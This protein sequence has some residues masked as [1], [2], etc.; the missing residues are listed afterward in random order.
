MHRRAFIQSAAASAGSAVF[1]TA[2]PAPRE[3][4]Y[5]WGSSSLGSSGYVIMEAFA[6]T[7]NRHTP[8]RSSSLA[9]AGT[10]EN[11]YLIGRGKL[12]FA[13]STSV[14]WMTALAGRKPYSR[15]VRANQLFAYAVWQQPPIVRA[16]SAVRT[17][18]DLAGH[19]FSPSLPGSGT[20][21]M[22]GVL[23]RSAGLHER[24]RWRYGSWS[25]IY[26]AFRADQIDAV[27]G[28]LTNGVR[29]S[30]IRQ[31]E[32]TLDLRV[33]RIPRRILLHAR[34]VNPGI[35]EHQLDG[36]D[37]PA[38]DGPM[39]VPALT[40]I[41][42]SSPEVS[43]ETGYVVTKAIIDRA[44]E[45]RKLGAPLSGLDIDSAVGNLVAAAPVNAGAAQYFRENGVWRDELAI[46]A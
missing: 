28:V 24:V 19:R 1:A 40:G 3:R 39:R 16:G 42:A 14:D 6:Q 17:F 25:E 29:S 2:F 35:L 8:Y 11:M 23:M 10:A 37:W 30:W 31:L 46:A 7:V 22:Y 12:E 9:T 34:S 4:I 5:R 33:V 43:A 41:V 27:V 21:A 32:S 45:V 20:A 38:I 13:H 44:A 15:P 18:C 36:A 26:T